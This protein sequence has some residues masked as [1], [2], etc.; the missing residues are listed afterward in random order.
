MGRVQPDRRFSRLSAAWD[1]LLARL[2]PSELWRG[3]VELERRAR[4]VLTFWFVAAIPWPLIFFFVYGPIL[5]CWPG[6]L[7]CGLGFLG[8][9][10][11]PAVLRRT[12]SP[13]VAGNMIL[14]LMLGT[15]LALTTISGGVHSPA[16]LWIAGAPLVALF[17]T[18][19][20]AGMAWT[21]VSVAIM[22]AEWAVHE[23]GGETLQLLTPDALH[24]L[25]VT[26]HIGLILLIGTLS[27]AYELQWRR[28]A[29]LAHERER[30]LHFAIDRAERHTRELAQSSA[31]LRVSEERL[32][33]A[34]EATSDAIWDWDIEADVLYQSPRWF[35]M[36]GLHPDGSTQGIESWERLIVDEDVSLVR[37]RIRQAQAER[38]SFEVEYR[39]RAAD[40]TTR[41]ILCRGRVTA[42][43]ADGRPLRMSGANADITDRR[44]AEDAA[45]EGEAVYRR[46]VQNSPMG[47]LF[48]ELHD[49]GGLVLT[50]VNAAADDLLGIRCA[51]LIGKRLEEAFPPLAATEIPDRYRAAAVDGLPW[52]CENFEYED[53]R[54]SGVYELRAFQTSP[55]KMVAVFMDV[56]ARVQATHALQVSEER[57]RTIFDV[58]TAG[59]FITDAEGRMTLVNRRM[60]ELFECEPELLVGREYLSLVHLDQ[61]EEARAHV[62]WLL[63]G[64]VPGVASVERRLVRPDGT[65]FWGLV[66]ARHL[67]AQGHF[68]GGLVGT[69]ADITSQ[70]RAEAALRASES[71]IA[72]QAGRAEVATDV[73]HNVGNVLNSIN[74]SAALLDE[75]LRQSEVPVVKR[76]AEMLDTH[77][78][79]M[80]TFLASDARGSK[81]PAFVHQLA[82]LLAAEHAFMRSELQS[83]AEAVEHI[84]FVISTQQVHG[85]NQGLVE[86][87]DPVAV[88]KQAL[89]MTAA[90]LRRRQVEVVETF[91]P[92]EPVPLY[93][94]KILQ[95]LVNLLTNARHALDGHQDQPRME[96]TVARVTTRQGERLRFRVADNGVGIAA[97]N[98]ERIFR[99]GFSTRRDGHGY[100]LHG[101]ANLAR[102]MG[103]EL[104]AASD[105]PGRGAVFTLDVPIAPVPAPS[106]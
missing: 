49:D 34:L 21:A 58:S 31:A 86:C 37:Q 64:A 77:R 91:E 18:G 33:L 82:D 85:R 83:L 57:L 105:G 7:I 61:R 8:F 52:T 81:L 89:G 45:R 104:R 56:T 12:R 29:A 62:L 97:E 5:D 103:G 66:S 39:A 47:M 98:L 42:S 60:A 30:L 54:L 15:L 6:A 25:T 71:Q 23:V 93:R 20:R 95:I 96:L 88:M 102:E 3:D 22:A 87:V 11:V 78:D 75:K 69:I 90:S 99:F 43:D 48:Y 100:G 14:G 79:D 44:R 1:R 63:S 13:A 38:G 67:A 35:A 2:A 19:L 101:S 46:L 24:V 55:G 94:H 17:V 53:S 70:K 72:L 68:A 51:A 76:L 106:Q 80:A 92:I 59:I 10:F 65:E 32:R 84:R 16:L 73:L 9:Q 26:G 27:A 36:L 41:W 28:A 74:V 50:D 4:T 40:G